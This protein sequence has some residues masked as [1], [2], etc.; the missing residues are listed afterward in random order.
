M[1]QMRRMLGVAL[2]LTLVFAVWGCQDDTTTTPGSQ[3]VTGQKLATARNS[4][5]LIIILPDS[6]LGVDT[7][8]ILPLVGG[9]LN[10]RACAFQVPAGALL[11]PLALRFELVANQPPKGLNDACNRI[12]KFGPD[13]TTF[14]RTCILTVPFDELGL[15]Q[16][17]PSKFACYYYNV[18]RRRYEIQ[19][20]SVDVTNRRYQVKVNHFSQYAFGR[21]DE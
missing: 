9:T 10:V 1:M 21:V 20:T 11:T 4:D 12:F 19:P 16:K 13:F 8:L 2:V 6:V 18:A 14:E 7:K 5:T 3:P 15:D 17:D